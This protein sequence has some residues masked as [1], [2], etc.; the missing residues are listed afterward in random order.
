M[1][2]DLLVEAVSELIVAVLRLAMT[3]RAGRHWTKCQEALIT[4]WGGAPDDEVAQARIAHE[5]DA[6]VLKLSA[7]HPN[8]PKSKAISRSIVD[9]ILGFIGRERV[10]AVHSAYGQGDWLEI[11]LDSAAEHLMSSSGGDVQWPSALDAYEGIHAIPLMTIRESKGLEY[12]SV[13]T[14]PGWTM[15]HGGAFPTIVSRLLLDSLWHLRAQNNGLSLH[16][17]RNAA[18]EEK[19][20]LFIGF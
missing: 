16:T 19:L 7:A 14:Q 15:A 3:T 12:H 1:L 20:R 11:V 17:A 18:H 13:I 10:I 2:Q 6:Y 5:L 4:L 9:D 8:P